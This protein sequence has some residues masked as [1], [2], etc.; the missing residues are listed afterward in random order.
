MSLS[1]NEKGIVMGD[2]KKLSNY[3]WAVLLVV[4]LIC[5]MGNYMQY[6]ISAWG[7]EVMDINQIDVAGLTSMMLL[8]ML[9]GVFL[10]IPAGM[11]ADKFGVKNV[12][13]AGLAVAVIGGFVR[14]FMI[15]VYPAQMAAMFML[16]FGIASLNANM[17]KIFGV[18]FK[19]QTSLAVGVYYASSCLAIVLAQACSTLFGTMYLSFLVAA[20][21]LAVVAVLW[22]L[23]MRDLPAGEEAPESEPITRYLG[24]AAK[25]RSVWLIAIA[26]GLTLGTTT[27]FASIL[28]SALE[29]G[30]GIETQTA[31]TMASVITI[32]SF[33]ACFAAPAW[34]MWRG[35]N[36]PFLIWSTV[37]GAAV[38]A[39]NWF[40]PLGPAMWVVL[41]LNGFFSALSG[42][43]IEAMIP[44]LPGIGTKYA[45]SAGGINSTVGVLI[46]YF[47]PIGI[48]AACGEDWVLNL[49]VCA[50]LFCAS[51]IPILFLPETGKK[52]KLAREGKLGLPGEGL[53]PSDGDAGDAL[54]SEEANELR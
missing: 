35:K 46:S 52:G 3:R 25:N 31:G 45:G 37:V 20:I 8:P 49:T 22:V 34:V 44:L 18:W 39:V 47:L 24:V 16:G 4:C 28:P 6:Q 38:M 50:I 2:T 17:T 7:V 32:G 33:A 48:A 1:P 30:M 27:Q 23:L 54:F 36:K 11:L 43:V 51:L 19:Q 29:L 12:V 5:F 53:S 41:I 13:V 26:Y 9:A 10:S 40:V 42:P 15:G 21:A 14:T